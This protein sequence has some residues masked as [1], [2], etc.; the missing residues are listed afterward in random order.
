MSLY[1]HIEILANIKCFMCEKE[2]EIVTDLLD[3]SDSLDY[4]YKKGWRVKNGNCICNK[5]LL[6]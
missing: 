4:F 6:K 2:E 5:C 3:S 1:E